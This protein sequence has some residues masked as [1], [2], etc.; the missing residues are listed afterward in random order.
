M[1]LRYER[2]AK[3]ITHLNLNMFL[4]MYALCYIY[5]KRSYHFGEYPASFTQSIKMLGQDTSKCENPISFSEC[6]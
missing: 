4:G 3:I 1:N 6:L 2:L 5:V